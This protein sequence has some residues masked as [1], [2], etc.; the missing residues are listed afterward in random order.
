[1][2]VC[3][4]LILSAKNITIPQKS[5][6]MKNGKI[7]H[8]HIVNRH[9]NYLPVCFMEISLSLSQHLFSPFLLFGY[10][11]FQCSGILFN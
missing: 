4:I 10:E 8:L 9:S 2:C 11:C 7:K 3:I 6:L 5:S 1:M